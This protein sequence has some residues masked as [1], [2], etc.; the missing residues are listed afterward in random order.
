MK[1]WVNFVEKK[2]MKIVGHFIVE[3]FYFL[4]QALNFLKYKKYQVN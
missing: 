1:I 2:G 3:I 4:V